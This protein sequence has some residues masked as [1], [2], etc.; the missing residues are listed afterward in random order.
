[1]K[2]YGIDMQGSLLVEEKATLSWVTGDDRRLVR[3]S[4]TDRLYIGS[5]SSFK[6]LLQ[7]INYVT[8]GGFPANF[9]T[10]LDTTYHPLEDQ[11]VSTTDTPTFTGIAGV[12]RTG[13]VGDIHIGVSAGASSTNTFGSNVVIGWE[14][15]ELQSG[16]NG[17]NVFLG[18]RAG[19]LCSNGDNTVTT[20]CNV[21]IGRLAGYNLH[22]STGNFFVGSYAGY[23]S[24]GSNNIGIGFN[25]LSYS[26]FS[27]SN[28]IS[29]G[30]SSG[31]ILST[32]YDNVIIGDNAG[33]FMTTG[34]SNTLVGRYTG[35]NIISGSKNICIGYGAKPS[36]A[37][38]SNQ[39]IIGGTGADVVN[40]GIGGNDNP[41]FALDAT[42]DVNVSGTFRI[43]GVDVI[44]SL[45]VSIVPTAAVMAFATV[46]VPYGWLPCDGG[47]YSNTTSGGL[48]NA[49]WLKI[50]TTYGGTGATNF[51]VPD[52]RGYFVRGSDAGRGVD[53][54]RTFGSNQTDGFRAHTHTYQDIS[55]GP[56]GGYDVTSSSPTQGLKILATSSAG[57]TE[58]RP[59]NIALQYCIK[60]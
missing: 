16:S 37:T 32:G 27:G 36:S 26:S 43:L 41:A 4:V 5:S 24:A 30:K 21:A 56:A 20:G 18:Y 39:C 34:Y 22:D 54:G 52:L 45:G 25:N 47:T 33:T 19:R 48:Y 8:G 1:M 46:T 49:L 3:N 40:V 31:K 57:G 60:Y 35:I 17:G 6:E 2:Y 11:N 10:A 28:N 23:S 13:V 15:G 59:Y 44:G 12:S 14:A 55:T 51:K 29:I 7:D 58:T 50:G 53:T 38:S 9:K 42:G